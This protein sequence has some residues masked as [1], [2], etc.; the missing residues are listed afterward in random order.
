MAERSGFFNAIRNADGTFDRAYRAEDYTE[1][2]SFVISNGVMRSNNDDLKVTATGLACSVNIGRGWINGHWYTNDSVFTFNPV[3]APTGNARLDRVF[4]RLDRNLATRS[5]RLVYRQGQAAIVPVAPAPVRSGDV[6]ELVL[7]DVYIAANASTA[8]V[9]DQ[10]NNKDLCGWVYSTAGDGSFFTSLDNQFDLWFSERKDDLASVTVEMEHK[11]FTVISSVTNTVS[12][13]LPQYDPTLNQKLTVFVNGIRDVEGV[14]YTV[15]GNTITF[16]NN[17]VAGSEVAIVITVAR[18]GSGIPSV[19]DDVAELQ[20]KVSAL[21]KGVTANTLNYFCN[22]VDDNVKISELVN[23]YVS[24]GDDY[25]DMTIRIH[26]TFGATAPMQGSGTSA[27]PYIWFVAG[28]GTEST[29]R[30]FLDFGNCSQ[31]TLPEAES[32]KYYCVFYGLQTY[33]KNCNLS[34]TGIGAYI[35]MFSSPATTTNYCENCRFWITALGG[36][37]SRGGTFKNC[38]LSLTTMGN[39]AY[40]FNVL[41]GGLLRVFG[42]EYYS[43]APIGNMSTVVYVN[44][45]QT[46]AVVLTYG[47]NCPENAR[48]G[49]VQ[50]YAVNCLTKSA[51]CSFTDTI[52]TL[53]IE[54][55]GQNIRGTI[56]QNKAGLM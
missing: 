15:D 55:A 49:Y 48:G 8:V 34:T 7:A 36:Y 32:G 14:D 17:L 22:G 12:I 43:Y 45:A 20:N 51:L 21:E 24:G 33:I 4:L 27:S 56:A 29:R 42:G 26:G 19:V 28:K 44:S 46:N 1:N 3:S 50:G 23:S 38:R 31:I 10:R 47:M 16:T 40:V 5:V 13:T 39:D 52:T 41:S 6:Y 2:L 9:M 37:I 25:S 30:V 53:P 18:N 54:A 35:Y 11:Q